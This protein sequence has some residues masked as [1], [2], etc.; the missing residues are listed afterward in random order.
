V[1][2]TPGEPGRDLDDEALA[3]VLD[4]LEPAADADDAE[5][6][7]HVRAE[8]DVAAIMRAFA[9]I[10]DALAAPAEPAVATVPVTDGDEGRGAVL[11]PF[12]TRL[13]RRAPI[14]AAAASLIAVV[15]LG[16]VLVNDDDLGS[17]SDDSSTSAAQGPNPAALPAMPESTMQ[18]QGEEQGYAGLSADDGDRAA[19]APA[20]KAAADTAAPADAEVPPAAESAGGAV[21]TTKTE[22]KASKS[23][24]ALDVAVSCNRG[25]FIG[26]VLSITPSGQR[27][28][29]RVAVTEW[30]SPDSGQAV[31]E[32]VVGKAYAN[33]PDGRTDLKLG[34]EWLF[35]VPASRD[36]AVRAFAG[37]DWSDAREQ[38]KVAQ[39]RTADN[40]C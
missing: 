27:Y 33:T 39:Q 3:R 8:E 16:V 10:G 29:L 25:I 40:P 28:T 31:R 38:I 12:A 37:P 18:R 26:R 30:I 5:R 9:V 34:Q 19:A 6:A 35:V 11:L 17:R 32:F 7:A 2:A 20:S 15:G 23:K 14:L 24:S 13:K 4:G 21:T 22:T 1:N 36:S